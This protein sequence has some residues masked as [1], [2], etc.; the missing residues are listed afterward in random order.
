LSL[1][2][3]ISLHFM[4]SPPISLSTILIWFCLRLGLPSGLLHLRF[5]PKSFMYFCLRYSNKHRYFHAQRICW[6]V[7]YKVLCLRNFVFVLVFYFLRKQERQWES[8]PV[9]LLLVVILRSAPLLF[10][11]VLTQI[12]LYWLLLELNEHGGWRSIPLGIFL[13]PPNVK[14][15]NTG[16]SHELR[17]RFV[18]T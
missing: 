1:S 6:F 4:P 12:H 13:S 5:P 14:V 7:Y 10:L 9:S 8:F 16:C 17:T 2:W 18:T 11:K 3:A 15:S